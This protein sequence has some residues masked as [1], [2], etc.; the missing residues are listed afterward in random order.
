MRT[1][2]LAFDVLEKRLFSKVVLKSVNNIRRLVVENAIVTMTYPV[3]PTTLKYS[4]FQI[5]HHTCKKW[6]F[7]DSNLTNETL[8]ITSK[9]FRTLPVPWERE[10]C[11]SSWRRCGGRHCPGSRCPWWYTRWEPVMTDHKYC[12]QCRSTLDVY[13]QYSNRFKAWFENNQEYLTSF[14]LI[15]I[16]WNKS[17]S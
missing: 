2:E 12:I 17:Y 15:K 6:F 7:L 3:K 9:G 16:W 11:R 4:S 1:S 10:R 14:W 8:F 5:S 13:K